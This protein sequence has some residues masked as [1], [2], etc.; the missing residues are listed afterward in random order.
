VLRED[1]LTGAT[2]VPPEQ[3]YTLNSRAVGDALAGVDYTVLK[4][5]L[6]YITFS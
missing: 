3:F 4:I 1:Q 5:A 6:T 2:S